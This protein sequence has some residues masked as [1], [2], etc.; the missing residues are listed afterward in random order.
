MPR[1]NKREPLRK[2]RNNSR[3]LATTR[4]RRARRRQGRIAALAP[5][6]AAAPSL[7]SSARDGKRNCDGV[8]GTRHWSMLQVASARPRRHRVDHHRRV[9]TRRR[10]PRR[11][12]RLAWARLARRQAPPPQR[13]PGSG[14]A[15]WSARSRAPRRPPRSLVDAPGRAAPGR[16]RTA[17]RIGGFRC[18]PGTRRERTSARHRSKLTVRPDPGH[19]IASRR[20]QHEP[21]VPFAASA[22]QQRLDRSNFGWCSSPREVVTS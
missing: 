2:R 22:S 10:P 13:S 6:A 7:T 9:T 21:A 16:G 18:N 12:R 17:N 4:D 3:T 11:R 1:G 8:Q 20:A 19:G 14:P 15:R 5:P